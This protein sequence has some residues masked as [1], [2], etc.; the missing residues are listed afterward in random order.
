LGGTTPT[1][2]VLP[3]ATLRSVWLVL[4]GAAALVSMVLGVVVLVADNRGPSHHRDRPRPPRATHTAAVPP[5]VTRRRA[6]APGW[7]L[8]SRH[9]RRDLRGAHRPPCGDAARPLRVPAP[10][11]GHGAPALP[12]HARPVVDGRQRVLRAVRRAARR[13]RRQRR[14]RQPTRDPRLSRAAHEH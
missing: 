7:R 10:R 6:F 9:P 4:I 2:E 5:T 11:R 8:R 12:A 3:T 13:A 1:V 14:G